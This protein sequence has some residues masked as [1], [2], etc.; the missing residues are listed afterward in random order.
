[1]LQ[2]MSLSRSLRINHMP[3]KEGK[4]EEEK[5]KETGSWNKID[6][7][8]N[9]VMA[10]SSAGSPESCS[11]PGWTRAS[12]T[13]E[14]KLTLALEVESK[15]RVMYKNGVN[16][17]DLHV[18]VQEEGACLC[19]HDQRYSHTVIRRIR[20]GLWGRLVSVMCVFVCVQILSLVAVWSTSEIKHEQMHRIL[21]R[22]FTSYP[23]R[24]PPGAGS[25]P[26]KWDTAFGTKYIISSLG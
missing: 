22:I 17:H 25:T 7:N 9:Y 13:A 16:K 23:L 15:A 12:L 20:A 11:Q 10:S 6:P 5:E 14:W 24:I 26:G 8:N 4:K 1:M 19:W 21:I 2:K 18:F 3:E